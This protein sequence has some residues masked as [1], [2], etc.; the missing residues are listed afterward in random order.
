MPRNPKKQN[1]P[2]RVT[3][4]KGMENKKHID[5]VMGHMLD[6]LADSHQPDYDRILQNAQQEIR[7]RQA[8]KRRRR[9]RGIAVA[10]L[11]VV[12]LAFSCAVITFD[13]GYA[14]HFRQFFTR[15]S[16]QE[17]EE[18]VDNEID[19]EKQTEFVY[20]TI[21]QEEL[22]TIPLF[23]NA[24]PQYIPSA[25]VVGEIQV[26]SVFDEIWKII[27]FFNNTKT[28]ENITYEISKTEHKTTRADLI[29]Y[30]EGEIKT[31]SVNGMIYT[32]S[33]VEK[34]KSN[35]VQ[36][37]GNEKLYVIYGN[38]TPEELLKMATSV[39]MEEKAEK[40]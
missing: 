32:Y 4:E 12:L 28:R 21:D 14:G 16:G 23:H 2:G 34:G 6:E 35:I 37:D 17:G 7:R 24:F 38:E 31:K 8:Q 19:G 20:Q 40:K 33:D 9:R 26:V 5:K 11:F 18:I 10:S 29:D 27:I 3:E 36:W 22:Y 1:E 25:Y 13:Q 30:E 39:D 15:D